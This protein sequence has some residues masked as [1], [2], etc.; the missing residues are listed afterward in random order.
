MIFYKN[1]AEQTKKRRDAINRVSTNR[2][3]TTL[4]ASPHQI[5]VPLR[6]LKIIGVSVHILVAAT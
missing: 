3:S 2:V 6:Q 4:I 5:I 1:F